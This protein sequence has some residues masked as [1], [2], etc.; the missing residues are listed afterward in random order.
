MHLCDLTQGIPTLSS[1]IF[2]ARCFVLVINILVYYLLLPSWEKIKTWVLARTLNRWFVSYPRSPKNV[3]IPWKH[4]PYYRTMYALF[5]TTN[6]TTLV[7][8][9]NAKNIIEIIVIYLQSKA[10]SLCSLASTPNTIFR[11]FASLPA[12][13]CRGE[14]LA[15]SGFEEEAPPTSQVD[16]GV[17]NR[18]PTQL[19]LRE[20]TNHVLSFV[21]SSDV[22]RN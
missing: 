8:G 14:L 17:R 1:I 21:R 10:R 18:G 20:L 12:I 15:W 9:W 7:P 16:R 5:S 13:A 22:S 11:S 2:H 19:Y 6:C 4:R 3:L